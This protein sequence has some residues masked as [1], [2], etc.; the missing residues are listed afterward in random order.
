MI[1]ESTGNDTAVGVLYHYCIRDSYAK[2]GSNSRD[3]HDGVIR[4]Q[5]EIKDVE[6]YNELRK[7]LKK[8]HGFANFSFE[9]VS[10]T[11]L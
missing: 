1:K 8:K 2:G 5:S 9:I 4:L 7:I 3:Q 6:D 11:R 10:L